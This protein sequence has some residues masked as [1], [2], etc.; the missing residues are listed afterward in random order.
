MS[1]FAEARGRN[2]AISEPLLQEKAQLIEPELG[3]TSFKA[4]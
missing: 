4:S 3:A 1:W 2:I